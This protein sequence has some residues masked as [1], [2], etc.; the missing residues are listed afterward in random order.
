MDYELKHYFRAT[1]DQ[2]RSLRTVDFP[3]TGD[4]QESHRRAT[5][6]PQSLM[7][8]IRALG[9]LPQ[10]VTGETTQQLYVRSLRRLRKLAAAG[11]MRAE[12]VCTRHPQA[13][14]TGPVARRERPPDLG[15]SADETENR[16]DQN[17]LMMCSRIQ[18]RARLGRIQRCK[19]HLKDSAL[20]FTPLAERHH[21]W[22]TMPVSSAV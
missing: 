22:D 9:R 13:S 14:A 17:M 10:D 8:E 21:V 18:S 4:P 15:P 6:E 16:L 11:D 19:T 3:N 5:G 2:E 7:E 20:R 1:Y 12:D